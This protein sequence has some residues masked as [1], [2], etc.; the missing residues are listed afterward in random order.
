MGLLPPVIYEPRHGAAVTSD[1]R[2]RPER[3]ICAFADDIGPRKDARDP[4][5]TAARRGG[6][7]AG[8]SAMYTVDEWHDFYV[9]VG[10]AAAVLTGLVF[11]GISI[12][13]RSVIAT[14]LFRARA[15]Y[16]TAG[17]LLS[18][19][20]SGFVLVPRQ[21]VTVL[22]GELI[23]L[24]VALAAGFAVPLARLVFQSDGDA[25]VDSQIRQVS[26]FVGIAL[27]ILSGVSLILRRGG[28]LY[29]LMAGVLLAIAT[30]IGGAW[31]LL[32][33]AEAQAELDDELRDDRREY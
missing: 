18:L 2:G 24:G 25:P 29:L 21:S 30:C 7:M 19:L 22:G 26:G 12:H 27:W 4:F 23:A 11:V 28:G 1:T 32:A 13:L 17:L 10:G 15:R 9:M 20:T 5:R 14:P 33:G 3:A 16:L 6:V 8:R 31:S